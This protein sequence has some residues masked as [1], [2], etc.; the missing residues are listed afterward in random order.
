MRIIAGTARGRQ[1]DAPEGMA[2]RP[3]LERVK[4][5]FFGTI[6]FDIAGKT[7]LDLFAGS[8]NLGIEALSRG[9]EFAYF[10]DAS[11]VCTDLISKNLQKI[12][13]CN[14]SV[15]NCDYMQ[16]LSFLK[17]A[18]KKA[19]LVFL[20]PPYATGLV[21]NAIDELQSMELL[22]D[23]CIIVAEHSCTQTV[24]SGDGLYI[25]SCK[26]YRDTAVTILKRKIS[27]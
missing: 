9:A 24:I 5:S 23:D 20:D 12:G 2:T 26:K 11:R 3:T 18:G 4:E 1:I 15:H 22:T 16:M 10:C 8:G 13:F 21:Q 17:S 14:A 25:H 6:Q 19:G 7:V 27:G